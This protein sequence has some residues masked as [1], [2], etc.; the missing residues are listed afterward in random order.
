MQLHFASKKIYYEIPLKVYTRKHMHWCPT[1]P[2]DSIPQ[3]LTTHFSVD[4]IT[5]CSHHVQFPFMFRYFNFVSH[6]F[7]FFLL[8]HAHLNLSSPQPIESTRNY[9]LGEKYVAEIQYIFA[10]DPLLNHRHVLARV[11]A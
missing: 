8:F 10:V 5:S 9:W 4:L 1:N 6:N 2:Y 3:Y 7:H 11:F